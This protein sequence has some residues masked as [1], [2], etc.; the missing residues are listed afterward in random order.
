MIEPSPRAALDAV[1]S[2]VPGRPPGTAGNGPA[3]K[4][5][6]NENPF[7]PLPSVLA[8]ATEAVGTMNRYPDMFSV[9][10][11]E[12]IAAARQVPVEDVVVGTGS[13]GVLSQTLNAM[14]DP[15]D[16][17]VYA[18]RSFEAYP[19]MVALTGARSVQVPLTPDGRHDLRAMADAVTDQTE[20]ILVCSPNNPTGP[21]VRAL[22]LEEFLGWV[23]PDVLV[24]IDEAYTE[25]GTDPAAA[26]A[27]AAYRRHQNVMVLR[28]FSKAYG[29]AGLRVGYA[30]AHPHIAMALR[31]AAVPF[32]VSHVAQRAA[33]ASLDAYPELLTRV[34]A[35]VAER[36][37]LLCALR[38]DGWAIPDTQ[39]NF[40]WLP[41]AEQ[42]NSFAEEATRAGIS[43]RP[44]PDEGVRVT[45]DCPEANDIFLDVARRF[46]RGGATS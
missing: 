43:V 11:T 33:L 34:D 25:F 38:Q 42:T 19:I 41:L 8:T 1:P 2:Y 37:R 24:V 7:P 21:A 4:M 40:V 14:C 18:W 35:V 22:E 31:K 23:P 39:A 10:L 9:E 15:G 3:Y 30:V 13:S 12:R 26:E 29:L 28:T 46:R 6:S 36:E 44:F 32:G 20:V 17:V 5:S 27:L 45:V 16:E